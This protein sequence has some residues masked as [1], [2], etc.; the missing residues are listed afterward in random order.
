MY[1][2]KKYDLGKYV[3]VY[4]HNLLLNVHTQTINWNKTGKCKTAEMTAKSTVLY[5]QAERLVSNL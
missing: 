3:H 5:K 1:Y 2:F 4:I